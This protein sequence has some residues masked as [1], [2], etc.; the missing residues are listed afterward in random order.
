M[1]RTVE[2]RRSSEASLNGQSI[3]T[4]S[5]HREPDSDIYGQ[6]GAVFADGVCGADSGAPDEEI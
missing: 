1:S 6:L 4:F 2:L 3:L 5:S